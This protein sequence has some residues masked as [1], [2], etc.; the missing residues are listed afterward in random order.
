MAAAA[1]PVG[2]EVCR[3]TSTRSRRPSEPEQ[4]R[5]QRRGRRARRGSRPPPA[6]RRPPAGPEP[7][8]PDRGVEPAVQPASRGH[9]RVA[10]RVDGPGPMSPGRTR[11][12]RGHPATPAL[13][14]A[15]VP[16]KPRW[17][18]AIPGAISQ[19][20]NL[21]RQLLTRRDIERLFGVGKVRAAALMKTFGAELVGNQRTL[22]R[23]KLLQQLKKHRGRAAFRVEE[24]RRARL[25]AELQEARLT[26]VRFKV[27]VETMRSEAG[28]PAPGGV[29][30]ARADRG[31]VRGG[32][33]RPGATLHAGPGARERLGA[34]P[35][36]RRSLSRR[37]RRGDP[38]MTTE[39][40]VPSGAEPAIEA[41]RCQGRDAGPLAG[42]GEAARRIDR[43][44]R[45]GR[46]PGPERGVGDAAAGLLRAGE[47]GT[48]CRPTTGPPPPSTPTSRRAGSRTRSGALPD[49][50][51]G[52][53]AAHG[54]GARSAARAGDDQA[55]RRGCGAAAL[56]VLPHVPGDGDY[57]VPVERGDTR[58]RA[59]D[60]RAR[61]PKTLIVMAWPRWRSLH[62]QTPGWSCSRSL[63][64]GMRLDAENRCHRPLAPPTR[65]RGCRL[66]TEA[67]PRI[68]PSGLQPSRRLPLPG[69][70]LL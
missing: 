14:I 23:T 20:E 30:R 3:P 17:L 59:A 67:R 32:G 16:A 61:V 55:A 5:R 42:G 33:G 50:G 62:N 34:V 46:A 36:A 37:G 8:S 48:T 29:G 54:P 31:A 41:R 19:L 57:G 12:R 70:P 27:P 66:R 7:L 4:R 10:R 64:G 28:E 60:R 53:A 21:D 1:T 68:G 38:E 65:H 43:H 58:A 22:P 9:R 35:G 6:R 63:P 56:D 13:R 49:H 52:G 39:A 44:G 47:R 11:S 40:L 26:G 15:T 2:P 45:P 24:E 18:L 51:P 69:V 25:V